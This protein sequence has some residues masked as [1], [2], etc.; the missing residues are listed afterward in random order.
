MPELRK[1]PI[2]GRWVII[3][4]DR[5]KRPSDWERAGEPSRIVG[6]FCPFCPGNEDKT[7]REVVVVRPE[8]G[9]SDWSV[10]VVPNK[11]PALQI[12]G[13]LVRK[14]E[15]IYDWMSGI[16]AHE[17]VIETPDH[18]LEFPDYEAAHIEKIL[19]IF[20]ARIE[21]LR[22][23][24]RFK[25][26]QIFKNHGVAAGASLGHSHS[27]L[28]ATPILPKR[29]VEELE[30][31]KK[32]F[33]LKERC[34][35]CDIINQERAV[36]K[37]IIQETDDFIAIAPFAARFPYEMWILPKTHCS[38]YEN[39]EANQYLKLA[40]V[41]KDALLR[42]HKVLDAPPYNFVIHSSPIQEPAASDYHWHIEIIP[43]LTKIAGFEWG[44]GF[45]INAVA[46][47]QSAAHYRDAGL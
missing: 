40:E 6:T 42:V 18:N 35:F 14:G 20:K 34:I 46:P 24:T 27:Q 45:Y 23:D 47:E 9:A 1:D 28:I 2:V 16:G 15:G 37:R 25:Y 7:P 3:S 30:G 31:A 26:I 4:A 22:K 29:V 43:K 10:R 33:A 36:G 39:M 38:H 21:D 13:E 12:E 17:V 5:G 41:L 19:Q 8:S 32:H 44:T 11:F